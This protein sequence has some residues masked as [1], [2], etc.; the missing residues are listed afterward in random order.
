M[1]F[2]LDPY[3][4]NAPAPQL[5]MSDWNTDPY[6]LLAIGIF[7]ASTWLRRVARQECPAVV[8]RHRSFHCRF[9]FPALRPRGQ[10]TIDP[11]AGNS[12]ALSKF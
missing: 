11:R 12:F 9:R 7:A 1:T 8:L 6:L 4:G 5:L 3:C 10:T 2:G